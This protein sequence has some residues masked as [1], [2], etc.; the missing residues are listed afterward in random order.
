MVW[1][2]ERV[3]G[4]FWGASWG[5]E[6]FCSLYG[7]EDIENLVLICKEMEST[8]SPPHHPKKRA[9]SQVAHEPVYEPHP[10]PRSIVDLAPLLWEIQIIF[11]PPTP[12]SADFQEMTKRPESRRFKKLSEFGNFRRPRAV[13]YFTA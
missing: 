3:R 7:P 9:D 5:P 11:P 12:K 10:G 8:V 1:F 4:A 13:A 6:G 2:R